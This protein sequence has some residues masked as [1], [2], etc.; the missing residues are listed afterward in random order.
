MRGHS[1]QPEKECLVRVGEEIPEEFKY[2]GV[3]FTSEG[4]MER[5][6]YRRISAVMRTLRRGKEGAEPKDE[7][8]SLSVVLLSYPHLC[9]KLWVVTESTRLRVQAAEMS[10]LRRGGWGLP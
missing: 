6:V 4:R 7:A 2:L 10:C 8:L 9:Y 3:L 5:E 1:S